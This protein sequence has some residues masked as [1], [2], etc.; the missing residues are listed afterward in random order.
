MAKKTQKKSRGMPS[1]SCAVMEQHNYLAET[2]ETYQRNRRQIEAFSAVARLR[3]RTNIVRIP[4]VV[5]V[6]FHKDEENLERSQID[7]QIAALNR[8]FRAN[9]ADIVD[10]PEPFEPTVADPLIEFALAVR[11]P[12][13]NETTGITR[14]RTSLK[15]FPYNRL[16]RLATKKLDDL[17]KHDEFGKAAWPRDRYLNMWTCSIESGLLGYAQFPGGPASTDGVV[18]NNT[19]FGSGGTAQA[20]FNLGRTAVHEVGHWLDLLHIWGDDGQGCR[21][22]DNVTDTPNQAGSNG[23]DVRKEDFPHISCDNGPNGDM[24]MNYMDY[25]DDDTMVMFTS[26]QVARMNAALEGPRKA[27]TESDALMPI[28]TESMVLSEAEGP[29]AELR[30]SAAAEKGDRAELVFDGVS[31]V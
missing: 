13:G 12:M 4:V 29:G 25:V 20:P 6:I 10:V 16:D 2:D 3:P 30:A 28:V 7:S 9:N 23:S 22:S 31:W 26:G 17:I 18:I 24:F 5:H 15:E 14:T 19:A 27:L 8:D 21:G 1:R 11:D